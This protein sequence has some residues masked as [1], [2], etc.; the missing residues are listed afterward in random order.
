KTSRHQ[1]A[2]ARVAQRL[3]RFHH[4][5]VT[6]LVVARRQDAGRRVAPD[7]EDGAGKEARLLDE[8][9]S[10]RQPDGGLPGELCQAAAHFFERQRGLTDVGRAYLEGKGE[11]EQPASDDRQFAVAAMEWV[12][13]A[14]QQHWRGG[15][16]G[17]VPAVALHTEMGNFAAVEGFEQA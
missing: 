13:G 8:G 6:V 10:A 12:E 7:D 16:R 2:T 11:T 1:E 5:G 4:G 17:R 15:R 9:G 3:Q 14:G